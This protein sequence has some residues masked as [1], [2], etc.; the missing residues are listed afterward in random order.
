MLN[1]KYQERCFY[2]YH[3]NRSSTH[4]SD[5]LEF[6]PQNIN[7]MTGF[8]HTTDLDNRFRWKAVG[9]TKLNA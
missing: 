1:R 4:S 8:A 9:R 7:V 2:R 3:L 5:M 6:F